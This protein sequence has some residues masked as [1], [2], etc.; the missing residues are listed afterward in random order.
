MTTVPAARLWPTNPINPRAP[1]HL[2]R[3]CGTC[4]HFGAE[5]VRTRAPCALDGLDRA[6]GTDAA[7]CD[8][9]TRKDAKP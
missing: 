9:W 3:V 1:L 2:R 5:A 8:D 7:D 6:G 4:Q